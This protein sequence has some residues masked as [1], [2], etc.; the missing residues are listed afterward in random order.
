MN[1]EVSDFINAVVHWWILTVVCY[2]GVVTILGDGHSFEEVGHSESTL[3][4]TL[5]LQPLSP[6]W[7]YFQDV[8]N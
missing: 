8:M 6:L 1:H 2:W 4:G 3:K 7:S 5:E